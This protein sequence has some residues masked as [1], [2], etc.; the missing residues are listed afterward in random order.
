MSCHN[1]LVLFR[2][3][4]VESSHTSH[5]GQHH[6]ITA[7]V[8]LS[9][10]QVWKRIAVGPRELKGNGS[11]SEEVLVLHCLLLWFH[12]GSCGQ[13]VDPVQWRLSYTTWYLWLQG[14]PPLG[15]LIGREGH[16]HNQSG[17]C[18]I[19][20]DQI[21]KVKDV[22]KMPKVQPSTFIQMLEHL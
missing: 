7:H 9:E 5:H 11:V 8:T 3:Q 14:L 18:S 20:L 1:T 6:W 16:L 17:T 19:L 4:T 22:L 10:Q 13:R 15:C 21:C 12:S 2:M